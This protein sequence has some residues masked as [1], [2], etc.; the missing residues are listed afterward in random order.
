MALDNEFK[1]KTEELI[2]T[3]LEVYK[4]NPEAGVGQ[5]MK[6][7]WRI[8]N[9]GDFA[10]GY[11]VGEIAGSALTAF[12]H[13]HNREPTK[14]EYKEIFALVEKYSDEISRFFHKN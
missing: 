3:T 9:E 6:N 8:E 14:E 5:N 13:H 2:V 1:E 10:C 7:V 4:K 12:L 11:F